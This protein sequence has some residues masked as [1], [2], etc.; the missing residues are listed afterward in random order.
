VQVW[1]CLAIFFSVNVFLGI[2]VFQTKRLG[3]YARL[4]TEEAIIA[5]SVWVGR[6]LLGAMIAVTW[7]G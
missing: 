5:G 2:Q 7:G 3:A 6:R 1:D 4:H